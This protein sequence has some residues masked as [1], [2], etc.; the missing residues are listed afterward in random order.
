[1]SIENFENIEPANEPVAKERT[2]TQTEVNKFL[3]DERRKA[4]KK[5][6]AKAKAQQL[7]H[8]IE[9]AALGSDT[10]SPG[11]LTSVLKSRAVVIEKQDEDGGTGEWETLVDIDVVDE[12]TGETATTRVTPT[13]AIKV[14][15]KHPEFSRLF[16]SGKVSGVGASNSGGMQPQRDIDPAKLSTEDYMALR[17]QPGGRKRLGLG[18]QPTRR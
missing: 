13:G 9:R 5:F 4:E 16:N 11:V 2:F 8:D 10:H 12:E 1:M 17:S 3:A 7:N 14:M 15:K 6:S 18:N